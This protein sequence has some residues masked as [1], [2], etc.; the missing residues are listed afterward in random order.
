MH[1]CNGFSGGYKLDL[2]L[3]RGALSSS[4]AEEKENTSYA[5]MA[6]HASFISG[7]LSSNSYCM[8]G[9]GGWFE[10][11]SSLYYRWPQC[12]SVASLRTLSLDRNERLQMTQTHV[13][14]MPVRYILDILYP[15]GRT[16]YDDE[17]SC[18]D[19]T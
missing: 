3:K 9:S 12:T 18:S 17:Y 19:D 1:W 6:V 14:W 8:W 4:N 11:R 10:T 2:R 5:T 15:P 7:Q 16:A 13:L